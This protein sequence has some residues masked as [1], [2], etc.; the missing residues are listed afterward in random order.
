[1]W[2]RERSKVCSCYPEEQSSLSKTKS[3]DGLSY[4]ACNTR[5][6]NYSRSIYGLWIYGVAAKENGFSFIGIE[7]DEGYFQIA[8][9]R[10]GEDK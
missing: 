5:R 9:A 8:K 10:I 2:F 3:F 4:Q 1:M 7:K 6:R